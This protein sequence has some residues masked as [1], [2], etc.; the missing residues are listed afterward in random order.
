MI[1]KPRV[2]KDYDK[3]DVETR[4]QIKLTYPSGFSD[5][6]VSYT[7]KEGV[8]RTALPFETDEKYYLIRMTPSEAMQIV[9]DDEDFDASGVLKDEIKEEYEEKYNEFE[10][11]EEVDDSKDSYRDDGEDEYDDGAEEEDEGD[12]D[13]Y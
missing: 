12:N 2:V 8:R 11:M 9:D 4:E 13:D 3:L 10:S 5:N 1:N 6:L 7:D